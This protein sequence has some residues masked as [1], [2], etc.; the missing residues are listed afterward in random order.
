MVPYN[1]VGQQ[2]LGSGEVVGIFHVAEDLEL[3]LLLGTLCVPCQSWGS[4]AQDTH[5]LPQACAHFDF[6][7]P[8]LCLP[9]C[10]LL[11]TPSSSSVFLITPAPMA[12]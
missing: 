5:A 8:P 11:L 3:T 1:G 12:L 9:K 6:L 7:M 10:H 4:A 2:A